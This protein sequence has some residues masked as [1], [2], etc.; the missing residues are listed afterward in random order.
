[1]NYEDLLK[2]KILPE[3]EAGRPGF[4]KPHTEA[5]VEHVKAIVDN[6]PELNLDRDVLI[7]AAYAHDWGYS[8]L[9]KYGKPLDLKDVGDAK[10]AHMAI[11]ADKLKELLKDKVFDFLTKEQK[12]RAIHLVEIHDK[13]ELLKDN[14]ELILMEADTLGG[15]DVSKVTPSFD[16]ESN[17]R[18]MNGVRKIRFPLFITKYGKQKFEELYK[19]REDFYA[20]R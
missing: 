11:G 16:K 1:M 7:I 15:L 18:Y 5:V 10:K 2:Q 17:E 20:K 9:F 3:L 4:D 19:A 14:D 13:L 12:Q 8:G 6:A